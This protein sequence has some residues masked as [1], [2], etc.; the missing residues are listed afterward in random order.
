VFRIHDILVWIRM[1]IRRSMPQRN[2]SGIRSGYESGSCYFHHWPSR[3]QQKLIFLL[4]FSAYYF[5][6][7]HLHQF[8]KIKSQK[9]LTKQYR[10]QGFLNI[11]AWSGS[12]HLTSGS[13]PGSGRPKNMCIRWIRIQIR[14]RNTAGNTKMSQ[15]NACHWHSWHIIFSFANLPIKIIQSRKKNLVPMSLLAVLH[16]SK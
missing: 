10:N 14:I 7:V 9:E 1:W 8:S 15:C 3:G 13:W 6:K 12:K 11:F 4:N 2:G 5:L 16:L